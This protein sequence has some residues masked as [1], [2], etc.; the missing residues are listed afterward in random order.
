[1]PAVQGQDM[2]MGPSSGECKPSLRFASLLS[3]QRA[4]QCHAGLLLL[5]LLEKPQDGGWTLRAALA[6]HSALM[7]QPVVVSAT[8]MRP[9]PGDC[10]ASGPVM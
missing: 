9:Y 3:S 10:P 8:S 1:M 5:V 2:H 4:T 6:V 7:K